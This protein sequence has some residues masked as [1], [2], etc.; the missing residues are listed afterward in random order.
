M[1]LANLVAGAIAALVWGFVL[2][3]G[4]RLVGMIACANLPDFPLAGELAFSVV[5]P[6]AM[7]TLS[8]VSVALANYVPQPG[9]AITW[10]PFAALALALI[11]FGLVTGVSISA[12]ASGDCPF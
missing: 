12:S 7:L 4:M 1:R 10:F 8:V 9:R 2:L 5:V 6:T 11:Y 3:G